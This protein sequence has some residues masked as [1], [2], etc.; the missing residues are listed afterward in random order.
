MYESGG[1]TD[2]ERARAAFTQLGYDAKPQVVDDL[3][4]HIAASPTDQL[5]RAVSEVYDGAT[6]TLRTA[7][8]IAEQFRTGEMFWGEGLSGSGVYT[9]E[10][11]EAALAEYLSG[12]LA[13]LGR[14]VES[15][16]ATIIRM[17]AKPDARVLTATRRELQDLVDRTGIVDEMV[18]AASEGWDIVRVVKGDNVEVVVLNRGAMIVL[19]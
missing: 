15:G 4:P 6:Q 17:T 3:A 1:T 2:A 10:G 16:N 13:N 11:S 7:D 9:I 18:A 8:E 19:R 5:N 12:R 14:A